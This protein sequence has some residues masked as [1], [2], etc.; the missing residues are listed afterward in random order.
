MI[1]IQQST[2]ENV[3]KA[4]ANLAPFMS[5]EG[6]S[7]LSTAELQALIRPAGFYKQKAG[8]LQNW[9]AF[10]AEN[11]TDLSAYADFPTPELRRMLLDI[12]GVGLET[13]DSMLMYLF[14]R[15][16]FIADAY[17]LRLF[18]RLG[19]G[20][21][22]NYAAMQAEFQHLTEQAS[23]KQCKEWHACI[24]V[25]GKYFRKK[26]VTDEGFLLAP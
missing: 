8:Y 14:G 20:A 19:F 24:D 4:L 13:A 25:H 21:Y 7:A 23:L 11:G 26:Q 10:F 18:G 16:M 3:E 9:L 15:K 1:L 2:Q 22:K 12:K 17:A 6:L 5:F